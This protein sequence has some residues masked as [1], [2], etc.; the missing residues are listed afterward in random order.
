[1]AVYS[2]DP[3]NKKI[4]WKSVRDVVSSILQGEFWFTVNNVFVR[5]YLS[6]RVEENPLEYGKQTCTI[7]S[8]AQS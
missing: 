2:S 5:C 4:P 6:L 8:S 3:H 7:N 1:M